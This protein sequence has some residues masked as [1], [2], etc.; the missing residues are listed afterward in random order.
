MNGECKEGPSAIPNF[1]VSL[2]TPDRLGDPLPAILSIPRHLFTTAVAGEG[3]DIYTQPGFSPAVPTCP[4]PTTPSANSKP[5]EPR[6]SSYSLDWYL[7][8]PRSPYPFPSHIP[9][10]FT[11]GPH[12]RIH[13]FP[14]SPPPHITAPRKAPISHLPSST[15]PAPYRL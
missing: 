13:L 12:I 7:R 8:F 11:P 15:P 1:R 4:Y 2:Q 14:L 3:R 9:P 10:S 5:L 6:S